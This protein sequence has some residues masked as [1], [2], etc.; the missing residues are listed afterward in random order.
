M[1]IKAR[2]PKNAIRKHVEGRIK[3]LEDSIVFRLNALG[4]QCVNDAREALNLNSAAFPIKYGGN[5]VK[6]GL[7][8]NYIDDTGNLRASVSYAVIKDGKIIK[9]DYGTV[10]TGVSRSIAVE[11]ARNVPK[12]FGLVVMAGEDYAVHVEAQ[13]FNV[14]SSQELFVKSELPKFIEK[15]KKKI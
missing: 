5:K 3:Y 15:L 11:R 12:G 2:S 6:K 7:R 4:E 10:A 1:Q 13:G 8:G 14:I 9:A